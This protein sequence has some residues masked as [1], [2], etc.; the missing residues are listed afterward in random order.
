MNDWSIV[1]LNL[2]TWVD[3]CLYISS[4]KIPFSKS[5]KMSISKKRKSWKG[6]TSKTSLT[7]KKWSKHV[8]KYMVPKPKAYLSKISKRLWHRFSKIWVVFDQ[9][10]EKWKLDKKFSIKC[11][12]M[13]K[14]SYMFISISEIGHL[15][16]YQLC[17]TWL[18]WSLKF[19]ARL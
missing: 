8:L 17:M 5:S 1:S 6:F 11:W 15:S 4:K 13:G 9:K 12:H 16:L 7:R 19:R 18:N 14:G 10:Y 3:L 2:D